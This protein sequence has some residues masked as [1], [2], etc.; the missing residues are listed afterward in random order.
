MYYM[1]RRRAACHWQQALP[2][3]GDGCCR[4]RPTSSSRALE[5]QL[6]QACLLEDST[7]GTHE[8]GMELL[9]KARRPPV[10]QEHRSRG[11][12]QG[13]G[14]PIAPLSGGYHPP[15]G[16]ASGWQHTLRGSGGVESRLKC[17]VGGV[18][19]SARLYR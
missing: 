7:G 10:S 12:G 8:V 5:L 2:P 19:H 9:L 6:K 15:R 11:L 14:L 1:R 18:A 3:F 4:R 17:A 16:W 13:G